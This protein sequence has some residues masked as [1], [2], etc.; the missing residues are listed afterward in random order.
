MLFA[1]PQVQAQLASDRAAESKM[2]VDLQH[3]VDE[4]S[5]LIRQLS[6]Q[7]A[8]A[9][10]GLRLRACVEARVRAESVRRGWEG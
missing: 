6:N 7:V 10:E 3:V 1:G 9:T 8:P 4:L 5:R 2:V